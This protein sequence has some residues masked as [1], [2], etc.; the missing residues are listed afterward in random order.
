M[1]F[2]RDTQKRACVFFCT[3]AV[4]VMWQRFLSGLFFTIYKMLCLIFERNRHSNL[5]NPMN[6][7]RHMT[8]LR[9]THHA[10]RITHHAS[11]ITLLLFLTACNALTPASTPTPSPLPAPTAT[12]TTLVTTMPEGTPTPVPTPEPETL[13]I[14]TSE[15]D[16]A[17]TLLLELAAE[18]DAGSAAQVEVIPKSVAGLRADLIA[19]ELAGE[20]P[21]DLLWGDEEDLAG[22]LTDGQLQPLDLVEGAETFVPA[23]ITSATAEG[24]IWGQPIAAQDFLLLFY[25]LALIQE[26]PR[27][28]D[29]L[30]VQASAIQTSGQAG[31]VAA[32]NEALW[33]LPWLNGFGGTPTSPDGTW[34]TL[35]TPAMVN[36]LDL[37][38]ELR[39]AAPPDQLD[40]DQAS[41]RFSASEAALAVDGMW[42]LPGYRNLEPAINVAV[43]PLP[44]VPATNRL[45]APALGVTYLMFHR[46][47]EGEELQQGQDFARF[48]V[49]PDV[50][51]RIA[52][53][54]QRLPA[55]HT[56]LVS[57][58]INGDAVLVA[59]A[60]QAEEALGLPPTLALRCALSGINVQLPAFLKEQIDQ[61]QAAAAMQQFAE[62]CMVE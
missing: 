50:Q 9:V 39:A 2:G 38:R 8:H 13:T 60:A 4:I 14:W 43:A 24:Q 45:A 46:T 15:R 52:S 61:Q 27:T 32:W 19:V 44:R 54:L 11:R 62:T 28:T 30:I 57:P 5:I 12:L 31:I 23:T 41:A 42:A 58:A 22:L 55:L 1:R 3:W 25:N 16:V 17:L 6:I 51:L 26:P 56:S 29:Q 7:R 34:P 20:P 48:L 40:Y 35:N 33:L 59:A 47:L 18:F 36:A 37:V 53:D 49:Q 10:S 21:P